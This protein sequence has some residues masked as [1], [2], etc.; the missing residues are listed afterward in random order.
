MATL[1]PVAVTRLKLSES[2]SARQ[3]VVSIT[4]GVRLDP[5]IDA[6]PSF[7]N[8][9]VQVSLGT[10]LR[11]VVAYDG[12]T[13]T[14][15]RKRRKRV[16]ELREA[17]M[18]AKAAALAKWRADRDYEKARLKAESRYYHTY[19]FFVSK[20]FRFETRTRVG[21]LRIEEVRKTVWNYEWRPRKMPPNWV[22]KPLVQKAWRKV[23]SEYRGKHQLSYSYWL[24]RV[25]VY[26]RIQLFKHI[27][28]KI[29]YV[30]GVPTTQSIRDAQGRTGLWR[31]DKASYRVKFADWLSSHPVDMYYDEFDVWRKRDEFKKALRERTSLVIRECQQETTGAVFQ[32]DP[33][34]PVGSGYKHLEFSDE[35]FEFAGFLYKLGLF[36]GV[37]NPSEANNYHTYGLYLPCPRTAHVVIPGGEY[38]WSFNGTG[39]SETC[40]RSALR[41]DA[42]PSTQSSRTVWDSDSK[43]S[44][45]LETDLEH[46]AIQLTQLD[47]RT[48]DEFNLFRAA[49][50][51]KDTK[52]TFDIGKSFLNWLRS[53]KPRRRDKLGNHYGG[54]DPRTIGLYAA[55]TELGL[56]S[57]NTNRK[58]ARAIGNLADLLVKKLALGG[59]TTR[60][61]S[62]L[63]FA[64]GVYLCYK[65]GVCPTVEDVAF[66]VGS[67]KEYLFGVRHGLRELVMALNIHADEKYVLAAR[68][69]YES[70]DNVWSYPAVMPETSLSP[71]HLNYRIVP[72]RSMYRLEGVP[73]IYDPQADSLTVE[74]RIL[75]N[76]GEQADWDVQI[77]S[78]GRWYPTIYTV[79]H[80][81]LWDSE[82]MQRANLVEFENFLWETALNAIDIPFLL[83]QRY[84]RARV[85]A[86]FY[87]ETLRSATKVLDSS[88]RI[89][90]SLKAVET[91]FEVTPFSWALGWVTDISKVVRTYQ[92]CASSFFN[93]FVQAG[94]LWGSVRA[95]AYVGR[96]IVDIIHSRRLVVPDASNYHEDTVSVPGYGYTISARSTVSP[97]LMVEET[98]QPVLTDRRVMMYRQPC[99]LFRRSEIRNDYTDLRLR[100]QVR[101]NSSKIAAAAAV[102][103]GF[104]PSK[105]R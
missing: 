54:H 20:R 48:K 25:R 68:V 16:K 80:P 2:S 36:V 61:L 85:F 70:K 49:V 44:F 27:T 84:T 66:V 39:S 105:F 52:A 43:T 28:G 24:Q 92:N 98:Y 9:S 33:N 40:K 90:N 79:P 11:S 14:A 13:S 76:L 58:V 45:D 94:P 41:A 35:Q 82:S 15:E 81:I 5:D 60:L 75:T 88:D 100:L 78:G 57:A 3:E 86:E 101:L 21:L 77:Q 91:A 22:P 56:F 93:D 38:T 47:F 26:K 63:Q 102:L 30:A 7:E 64:A 17:W 97:W 67:T 42:L 74:R 87:G 18:A 59:F 23:L 96:P 53:L 10:P 72:R 46:A 83:G 51:L 73:G 37:H 31:F 32:T 55:L 103:V 29:K 71:Y 8:G 99:K 69:P 12:R 104:L 50:E 1:F 6:V 95:T 4:P 89:L 34:Q 62:S 65:W 19:G